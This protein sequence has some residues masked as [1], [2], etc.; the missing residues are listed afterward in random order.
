MCASVPFVETF[1]KYKKVEFLQMLEA[2]VCIFILT[3]RQD[4]CEVDLVYSH[5]LGKLQ[6][7]QHQV[8][9]EVPHLAWPAP[10]ESR[11]GTTT[12]VHKGFLL[13]Y[14][15]LIKTCNK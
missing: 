9:P 15:Y 1:L 10:T 6:H 2:W 11:Q 8:R 7:Q 3:I 12:Y 5:H 13:P 14:N 4:S